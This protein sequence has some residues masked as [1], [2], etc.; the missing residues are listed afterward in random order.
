M[1]KYDRAVPILRWPDQLLGW[2]DQ[3]PHALLLF[4]TICAPSVLFT[5]LPPFSLPA[6]LPCCSITAEGV[7]AVAPCRVM[8]H[9]RA[10][11]RFPWGWGGGGTGPRHGEMAPTLSLQLLT[12]FLGGRTNFPGGRTSF[13]GSASR[14]R[15]CRTPSSFRGCYPPPR[16]RAP[17]PP[18]CLLHHRG[19]GG[20]GRGAMS[21]G[22]VPP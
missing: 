14:S 15:S 16:S 22:P 5:S 6:T 18:R 9:T 20:E 7:G 3:L 11:C 4:G 10:R 19:G 1:R 13:S 2:P 12:H 8:Y 21:C 17:C